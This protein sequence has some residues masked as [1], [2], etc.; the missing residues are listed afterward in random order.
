L[1]FSPLLKQLIDALRVLPGVGAKSAQRMAF[2][3]LE[4]DREG[5]ARLAQTLSQAVRQVAHCQ[6]CRLLCEETRC[7]ICDNKNRDHGLICIVEGPA[8]VAAIEQTGYHGLYFVLSGHLSPIDGIGPK[9]IG[10][11]ALLARLQGGDIHEVILATNSTVEGEAT[12][13]FIADLV[14]KHGIK[15]SRIAH[16]IPM[17]GELDYVDGGTIAKALTDRIVV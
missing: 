2:Y 9:E 1:N 14:K 6:H 12:A 13:Y 11:E 8:H 10:I 3:I 5:G 16:G 17:G 7:M 15:V 4:R